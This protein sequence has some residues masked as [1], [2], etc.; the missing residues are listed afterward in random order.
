MSR[1]AAPL[2]GRRVVVTRA[3][4]QAGGLS[5]ALAAL[6]AEVVVFPTI[7]IVP[8]ADPE[9]LRR[10]AREA[11][12]FDW[13]VFTST[14]G[15]ERF[16]TA[17]EETGR[18]ARALAG[19]RV[20]AVGPATAAELARRG[21]APDLVPPEAVADSAA[22]ALVRAER[23]TGRR[24][25]LPRAEIARSVLPDALRAAGAEVV[26]VA[27]YRTVPDGEGAEEV[28]RMLDAGRVDLVAFSAGS[29]VRAFAE[30]VGAPGRAKVASI[31]PVT[32]RVAREVGLAVDVEA[33]E[34]T[35]P[36]LVAAI[37]GLYEGERG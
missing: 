7:R 12:S 36:G 13:I 14:N 10:A 26:E 31:G 33:G 35:I 27:A 17:L 29:T 2:A 25:L 5:A 24:V 34:H 8:P 16:W 9:P 1:A 4:A 11:G 18:G 6:G 22:D 37:R 15:V 30:L 23:M 28:R 3:R 19:V 20:C 32:S 21:A